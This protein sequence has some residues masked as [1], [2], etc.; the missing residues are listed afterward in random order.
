MIQASHTRIQGLGSG[1]Q[2]LRVSDSGIRV[3]VS[4]WRFEV[5]AGIVK[6]VWVY[7]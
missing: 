3:E 4:E 5:V 2:V 7:G 1:V 6:G